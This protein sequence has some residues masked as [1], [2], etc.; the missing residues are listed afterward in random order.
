MPD[1][2]AGAG[3][4][5]AAGR[6]AGVPCGGLLWNP[7]IAVIGREE[8]GAA[9][10]AGRGAPVARAEPLAPGDQSVFLGSGAGEGTLELLILTIQLLVL[11]MPEPGKCGRQY[12]PREFRTWG[13]NPESTQTA[14]LSDLGHMRNRYIGAKAQ[15]FVRV[16]SG[17][18]LGSGM[19][20]CPKL[21]N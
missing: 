6:G 13:S 17:A 1:A 4:W 5:G 20:G 10:A 2:G 12:R 3:R 8:A 14:G 11:E 21:P 18:M 7:G 9:A 16:L 19:L 15:H